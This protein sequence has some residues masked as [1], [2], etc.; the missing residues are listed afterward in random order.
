MSRTVFFETEVE[1]S[2]VPTSLIEV[3]TVYPTILIEVEIDEDSVIGM[4]ATLIDGD[5]ISPSQ[6]MVR[7]WAQDYLDSD[8]GS[9]RLQEAFYGR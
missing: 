9:N 3:E 7:E 8:A 6:K 2:F 4:S 1:V 5:G